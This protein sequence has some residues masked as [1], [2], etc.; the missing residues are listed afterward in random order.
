MAGSEHDGDSPAERRK[1]LRIPVPVSFMINVIDRETG[2]LY[3]A[4]LLDYSTGGVGIRWDSCTGCPGYL[5]GGIDPDCFFAP[6]D[7]SNPD[8]RELRFHLELGN[9]DQDINFSGKAVYTLKKDEGE[10]IGI[11]FTDISPEMIEFMRKV[12]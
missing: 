2:L 11:L 6:F 7:A 4:E 3:P 8:S 1:S 10:R 9:Y 5:P 12:F